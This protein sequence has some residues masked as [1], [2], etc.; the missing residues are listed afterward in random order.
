MVILDTDTQV[1]KPHAH[2]SLDEQ[3]PASKRN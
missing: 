1:Y 3:Q 2:L